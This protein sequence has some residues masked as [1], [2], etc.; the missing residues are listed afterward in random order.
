MDPAVV[1]SA[2]K[3][4]SNWIETA[5]SQNDEEAANLFFLEQILEVLDDPENDEIDE[6]NVL[7]I[8]L[9]LLRMKDHET[10]E[11]VF[12]FWEVLALTIACLN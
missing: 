4:L 10:N 8:R 1:D 5:P 9:S 6:L 11:E 7:I 2:I 3:K 12:N